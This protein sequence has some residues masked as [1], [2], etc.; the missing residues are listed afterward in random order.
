MRG[1]SD[2]IAEVGASSLAQMGQVMGAVMAKTKGQADGGRQV[3][4]DRRAPQ[5]PPELSPQARNRMEDFFEKHSWIDRTNARDPITAVV[6]GI[7][8][9]V[10]NQGL[11]PESQEYWD[12][13][14]DM[15]AASPKLRP[16]MDDDRQDDPP[17]RRDANGGR[18]QQAPIRRGPAVGGGSERGAGA[19]PARPGVQQVFL[20]PGR[21]QAMIAAGTLG[22]DGK[23]V[24]NREKFDR[25]M[26]QFAAY[27]AENGQQA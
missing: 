5:R 11:R 1:V 3:N 20:S 13:V 21:R 6:L 4:D 12:T 7:D 17:P 14:E 8:L 24:Q 25:Q 15:M 23:T 26:K 16:F 10:A 27:D 19:P 22:S 18:Q 2:V 9:L